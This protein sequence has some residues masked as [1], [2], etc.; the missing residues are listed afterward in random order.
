MA[1][2]C[3]VALAAHAAAPQPE[4]VSIASRDG[5]P[6]VAWLFRPPDR[7][8]RG[9]VIALHGCGGLYAGRDAASGRFTAR[10]QAMADMLVAE[11]YNV[12]WPDSLKPRGE[13]EL[14][15]QRIGSR[16]IDQRQ[17]RADALGALDWLAAQPWA[18]AGRYAVLGWS[19]GGSA[20][21]SA[22]DATR[23]DVLAR[24][25]RFA[26]AIAFYPGCSAALKSGW[27]PDTR[28][29][30]LLGEKDDWTPPQPCTDL[31]AKTG[32]EAVVYPGSYHDFDNPLGRVKLRRDVPNGLHPGEGVHAGPEPDARAAANARVRDTLRTALGGGQP[33]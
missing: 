13:T 32:A 24:P 9:S 8:A 20:V 16:R 6:L 25:E 12:L 10:H 30:M 23:A 2:A 4:K 11:G 1:W 28:V 33:R 18:P 26:V 19:H 27:R 15:T 5:T 31:A 7:A 3:A 21:L 14:C 22:T 29:V 17:R